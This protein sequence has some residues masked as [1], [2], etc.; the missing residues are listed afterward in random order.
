MNTLV[1]WD[2]FRTRWNLLKDREE[3]ESRLAMRRSTRCL[4]CDAWSCSSNL[5]CEPVAAT[6][7]AI[8]LIGSRI[9]R[10]CTFSATTKKAR[11][12]PCRTVATAQRRPVPRP[13]K[14]GAALLAAPV[15]TLFGTVHSHRSLRENGGL[16]HDEV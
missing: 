16:R 1:R 13:A 11:P 2:P 3:L 12:R 8:R 4:I 15:P 9:T 6:T 10:T 14:P 5:G 7:A